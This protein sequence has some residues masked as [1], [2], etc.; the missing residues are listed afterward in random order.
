MPRTLPVALI[1]FCSGLCRTQDFPLPCPLG[2]R[3]KPLIQETT[4]PQRIM[5]T[6]PAASEISVQLLSGIHSQVSH[7]G[8]PVKAQVLETV[9]VNGRAAI[10][11]GSFFDG[12]I[13]RIHAA[14][15]MRR[16]GE[17]AFRFE[18]ITLP[19]GQVRPIFG[20]LTSVDKARSPNSRLDPEGYLK[21]SRVGS[22]RSVAAGL[23]GF[24]AGTVPAARLLGSSAAKALLPAA[25]AAWL[26][27]EILWPRGNEVNIFPATRCS[28]R[29]NY[30]LTLYATS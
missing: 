1:L 22:Y 29:L 21:G 5:L 4:P 15:R 20:V 3:D 26:G 12:R 9:Y 27:Y 25:S 11:R 10:P 13:T 18:Q 6:I 2:H 30:P 14:G 23:V 24:G 8:D 16:P 28:I 7:L 19:D 17:L